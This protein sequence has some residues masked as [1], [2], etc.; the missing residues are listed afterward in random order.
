MT[1]RLRC[2][3]KEVKE[4][5]YATFKETDLFKVYQTCDLGGFSSKLKQSPELL[6]LRSSIYSNE[7][8]KLISDISGCGILSD[9]I[10]IALVIFIVRVD[11]F[12]VT[13]M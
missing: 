1:S 9:R 6:A 4:Q 8:C 13:M 7:F 2:V 10:L 11:I 3:L 5:L 12:S